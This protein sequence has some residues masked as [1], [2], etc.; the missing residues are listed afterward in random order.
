MLKLNP[1]ASNMTEVDNGQITV[2]FSYKTPVAAYVGGKFY[3]TAQR[4]SN[5]TARHISKWLGSQTVVDA[6]EFRPQAYFDDLL[7]AS[8][9][10]TGGK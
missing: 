5:T 1:I 7:G 4:W 9:E 6:A 10:I 8:L 2:L 3:R